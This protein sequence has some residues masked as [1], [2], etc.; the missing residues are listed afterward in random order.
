MLNVYGLD[1]PIKDPQTDKRKN[2]SRRHIRNDHEVTD[3]VSFPL[4]CLG[5]H[6][7]LGCRAGCTGFPPMSEHLCGR[8]GVLLNVP[9]A[10]T[11]YSHK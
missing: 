7:V 8:D 6:H 5:S 1:V 4:L 3:Q 2:L 11:F 9:S 10:I